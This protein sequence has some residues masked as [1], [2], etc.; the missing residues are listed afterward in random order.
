MIAPEKSVTD[1]HH[2][3]QGVFS[4]FDTDGSAGLDGEEAHRFFAA[5]VP[6]G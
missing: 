2:H 3:Y 1:L 6:L 5:E 4:S